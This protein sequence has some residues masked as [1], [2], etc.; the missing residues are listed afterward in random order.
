[1]GE[2]VRGGCSFAMMRNAFVAD[3]PLSSPESVLAAV[4]TELDRLAQRTGEDVATDRED[5]LA[6][7]E[8]IDAGLVARVIRT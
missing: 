5:L 7:I 8:E 1:M 6:R 3:A 2:I 4:R